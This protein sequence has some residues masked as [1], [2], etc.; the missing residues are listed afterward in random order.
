[1][2]IRTISAIVLLFTTATVSAQ[3][4]PQI[5]RRYAAYWTTLE[6]HT[7][8]IILRNTHIEDTFTVTPVLWLSNGQHRAL[9]P[10]TLAPNATATI[11]IGRAL[12]ELGLPPQWG[13]AE[14][15]YE[16]PNKDVLLAEITVSEGGGTIG[17]TVPT[18]EY[19]GQSRN[20]NALVLL[21][22]EDAGIYISAQNVSTSA[23][24]VLP[25]LEL[26]GRMNPLS[27]ITIPPRSAVTL[28]VPAS[29]FAESAPTPENPVPGRVVLQHQG[30]YGALN[31]VGWLEDEKI[32]FSSTVTFTDPA[33]VQSNSLYGSQVL[34]SLPVRGG[35][36][37]SSFLLLANTSDSLAPVD[38]E[39]LLN[40]PGGPVSVPLSL[41]VL[42]ANQTRML[43]LNDVMSRYRAISGAVK[44]F[45]PGAKGV[46]VGRLY[47]L[48]ADADLTLYSIL[49][50]D[51]YWYFRGLRWSIE[52]GADTLLTITNFSESPDDVRIEI[53]YDGGSREFPVLALG[54]RESRTISFRE[55]LGELEAPVPGQRGGFRVI[56]KCSSQS[57]LLVKEQ[58]VSANRKLAQPL[59]GNPNN[60][61]T[62]F[63][64]STSQITVSAT[65]VGSGAT[66]SV[67]GTLVWQDGFQQRECGTKMTVDD[68]SVATLA[69]SGCPRI[70]KGLSPGNTTLT[71]QIYAPGQSGSQTFQTTPTGVKTKG[72]VQITSTGVAPGTIRLTNPP[73]PPTTT[74]TVQVYASSNVPAG[75]WIKVSV[76]PYSVNPPELSFSRGLPQLM[77]ND[78]TPGETT[79]FVYDN[80]GFANMAGSL[81]I[82]ADVTERST[83]LFDIAPNAV[84]ELPSG[85]SRDAMTARSRLRIFS[86]R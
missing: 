68:T 26:A 18:Y 80:I 77:F 46:I 10:A 41:G 33:A 56:G 38:G 79:D 74:A 20:L 65:A 2:K 82:V 35:Q 81:K 27:A 5:L 24:T 83:D 12:R 32:G 75:S 60:Y 21:P 67:Y 48:T 17:Y 30:P 31:A 63:L 57:R 58:I 49:D 86:S 37:L 43:K 61:V 85:H 62:N 25:F 14:F 1:M 76:A 73:G 84:Y 3:P 23:I 4:E 42:P 36:P 19:V 34:A 51:P 22:S 15:R 53:F 6:N 55:M 52:R 16:H 69:S 47:S 45:Y 29:R 28:T 70:V 11:D 72:F 50:P 78:V 44:V 64:L 13:S 54:G 40:T 71:A 8:S 9:Q 66:Q 39:M 7:S 59:Y